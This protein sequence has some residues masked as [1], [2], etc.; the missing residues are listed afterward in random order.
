MLPISQNEDEGARQAT[1]GNNAA[2]MANS[3]KAIPVAVMYARIFSLASC[4][5]CPTG[6]FDVTTENADA[7]LGK[8]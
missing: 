2:H 7:A 3:P 6:R 5:H 1:S 4:Q 8:R